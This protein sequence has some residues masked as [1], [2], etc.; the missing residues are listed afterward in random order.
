MYLS[1]HTREGIRSGVAHDVDAKVQLGGIQ[2]ARFQDGDVE[3]GAREGRL[4]TIQS[5]DGRLD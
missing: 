3:D 4:P 1:T 5:N 2:P